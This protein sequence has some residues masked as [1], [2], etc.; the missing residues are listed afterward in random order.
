[1]KKK[2]TTEVGKSIESYAM[3]GTATFHRSIM[4]SLLRVYVKNNW[5]QTYLNIVKLA[6]ED[7]HISASEAKAFRQVDSLLRPGKVNVKSAIRILEGIIDDRNVS[8]AALAGAL[9]GR[10]NLH[11]GPMVDQ[12]PGPLHYKWWH[13]DAGGAIAGAYFGAGAGPVA[14]AASAAAG[15]AIFSVLAL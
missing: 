6:E 3:Y 14:A 10:D 12:G 2:N 13:A 7:G 11:A 5:E 15:A 1:M 9:V 8:A 4:R